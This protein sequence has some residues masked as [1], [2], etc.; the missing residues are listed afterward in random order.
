[1]TDVNG[2]SA[3]SLLRRSETASP[4]E[5]SLGDCAENRQEAGDWLERFDTPLRWT[6]GVPRHQEWEPEMSVSETVVQEFGES[7]A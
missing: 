7:A 1:M 2:R 6:S 3:L 5:A 4:S